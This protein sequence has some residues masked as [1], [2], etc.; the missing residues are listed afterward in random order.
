MSGRIAIVG[1]GG[2]VGSS[3]G[4]NLLLRPEPFEVVLIDRRPEMA[5][6]HEM[7]LQQVLAAGA[8]GSVEVG[9]LDAVAE[10]DV[11]V[12]C[13]SVPLTLNETRMV[14]LQGN[15][16]IVANVLDRLPDG[17]PGI[18]LLVTNPVDPLC[19]WTQRQ[20]GL[21]R[22]RVLGYTVN[23]SLRLR[24]VVA[25]LLGVRRT[26]V[27]AWVLGE[28]GDGCV[29]LLDR[30]AVDGAPV[31]LDADQRREA[32]AFL[33][34]WYVRHVALDSGRSST[35]ASGH[36]VAR[37]VSALRTPGDGLW[38][39]SVVLDGE[40]G[41]DGVAVSVPVTLGP[42]GAERVHE[43]ELGE[44]ELAALRAAAATIGAAASS[45]DGG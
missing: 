21:D 4:F 36:G 30:I 18:L 31:E 14:Y 37:M 25:D 27:D 9:T 44:P 22:R 34:G 13:A 15:V 2:G 1:A 17:W 5:I 29:P 33:R 24:T 16:A 38:P 28:H 40:Y 32:E 41:I 23:D 10:A 8:T 12:L 45:I 43:W 35:W 42:G 19:T 6:S 20:T 11:V 26:A 39:A 7:D 3:V